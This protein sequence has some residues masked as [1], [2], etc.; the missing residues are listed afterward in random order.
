MTTGHT[1]KERS[2]DTKA[3]A[4]AIGTEARVLR[5]FLRAPGSP[6][7]TVGSGSRYDFADDELEGLSRAFKA[8]Q[9]A[10]PTTHRT[11]RVDDLTKQTMRDE[12]VWA[13]EAELRT[14]R[15]L[16]PIILADLRDPRVRNRMLAK[17][18]AQQRRLEERLFAAGLHITQMRRRVS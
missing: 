12:E 3:A 7:S 18:S 1:T 17:A 10:K 15:G 5:R 14:R 11:A 6:V 2:M 4:T 8:W 9:Q 13:E 16:G